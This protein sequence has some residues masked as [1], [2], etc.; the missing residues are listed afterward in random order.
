MDDKGD[1]LVRFRAFDS[2]GAAVT[3]LALVT[4]YLIPVLGIGIIPQLL[5]ECICSYDPWA[6]ESKSQMIKRGSR[7]KNMQP[8]GERTKYFRKLRNWTQH[9]LAKYTG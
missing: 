7:V 6:M 5:F 4:A 2:G 3:A 8:S 1:R 9:D